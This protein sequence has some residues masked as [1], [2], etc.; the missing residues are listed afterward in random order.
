MLPSSGGALL[1][2][3]VTAAL[4]L[5]AGMMAVV[6][7]S[8]PIGRPI[9]IIARTPPDA[10]RRIGIMLSIVP[11]GL[12]RATRTRLLDVWP[13]TPNVLTGRHTGWRWPRRIALRLSRG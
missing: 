4:R 7:V 5:P 1:A 10:P 6:A 2:T 8:S 13:V 9:A 3:A 11:R 12:A